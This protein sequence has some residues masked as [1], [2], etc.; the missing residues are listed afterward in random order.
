MSTPTTKTAISLSIGDRDLPLEADLRNDPDRSHDL[1]GKT[2][3]V[4]PIAGGDLHDHRGQKAKVVGVITRFGQI[5]GF[6]V[7][8]KGRAYYGASKDFYYVR[9]YLEDIQPPTATSASLRGALA[10]WS[11]QRDYWHT[12]IDGLEAFCFD[13]ASATPR[14]I[15]ECYEWGWRLLVPSPM[16]GD[17]A[18]VDCRAPLH[19]NFWSLGAMVYPER[20]PVEPGA[21]LIEDH[22]ARVFTWTHYIAS[23]MMVRGYPWEQG[24]RSL[25]T[26]AEATTRI[27]RPMVDQILASCIQAKLDL[28]GE[29]TYF[30]PGSL[31]VAFSDVRL[32][33]ATVGLLEPP[34]DRRP[35]AVMSISP[36]A[37][38]K[39]GY[40]QQVVLHECLH[41]VVGSNG[42][43]PHNDLFLAMAEKLGLEPENQD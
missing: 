43:D 27:L 2:V 29:S 32:K 36:S 25:Q 12:R 38:R 17:R 34:T 33:A 9:E 42:G 35:Y 28:T 11:E 15:P 14:A 31:S 22:W 39:K 24:V 18:V 21:A 1:V 7:S 6:E 5:V 3:E 30:A 23:A 41:F 20:L 10:H 16:P 37:V 26:R 19:G 40:L 4:S 8:I 13:L